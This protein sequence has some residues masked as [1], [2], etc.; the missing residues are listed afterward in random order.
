MRFVCC[1]SEA[2]FVSIAFCAEISAYL[3]HMVNPAVVKARPVSSNHDVGA[4][5]RGWWRRLRRFSGCSA[6]VT[7][8]MQNPALANAKVYCRTKKGSFVTDSCA[9]A[10]SFSAALGCL[11]LFDRR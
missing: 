10:G 1:A 4:L 9:S 8:V 5:V 7:C 2:I 11:R 3:P 6:T